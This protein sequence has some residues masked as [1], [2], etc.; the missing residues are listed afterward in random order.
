MS[1][2]V[3]FII[4]EAYPD[5]KRPCLNQMFGACFKHEIPSYF[6]NK[7]AEFILERSDLDAVNNIEGIKDFWSQF[8]D[9]YYMDNH[10]WEANIFIDGKWVNV[11]PTDDEIL[12][13]IQK[14]KQWEEEDVERDCNRQSELSEEEEKEE[15]EEKAYQLSDEDK[16]VIDKMREYFEKEGLQVSDSE[17][18]TQQ[19][20]SSLN[21]FIL[22]TTIEKYNENEELFNNFIKTITRC[23]EKDIQKITSDL[24]IIYNEENSQKLANLMNLYGILIEYKSNFKI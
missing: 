20:I 19:V 22:N 11:T 9:E 12:E 7:A 13:R 17:D 15:K 3:P 1:N 4:S 10:P 24:E 14:L 6:I 2:K 18:K 23:L 5:Y 16:L 21:Q 8:Y